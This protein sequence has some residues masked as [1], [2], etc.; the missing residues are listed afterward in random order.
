M[1]LS[2]YVRC[3]ATE[4]KE[5]LDGGEMSADEVRETAL[6]AIEAV[7]PQIN[8]IVHGPFEEPAPHDPAGPFAGVPFA[9]KDLVC[10][11]AG[12]PIEFGSRMFEG[13]VAEADST[14]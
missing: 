5:L 8:S 14:L 3:D 11:V 2:D 7:E 12:Y 10:A 6:R 4:L 13:N 1:E 9:L